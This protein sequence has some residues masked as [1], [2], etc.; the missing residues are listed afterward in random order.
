MF[1]SQMQLAL[2]SPLG[3]LSIFAAF[4]QTV[5]ERGQQKKCH[6]G[7]SLVM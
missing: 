1:C 3:N 2:F 4:Y 6:A 7:G 5:I